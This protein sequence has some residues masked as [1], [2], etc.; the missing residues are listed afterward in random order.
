[1][2]PE[3]DLQQAVYGM[4]SSVKQQFLN[5][6]LMALFQRH[7]QHC[8]GYKNFIDGL[9]VTVTTA[10]DIPALTAAMF[11]YYDLK[12]VEDDL[13]FKVMHSSGTSSNQLSHIHL[14]RETAQ[15]QS[16]VLGKILQT[17][18][19]RQ[20]LPMLLV[21]HNTLLANKDL[22][23]ARGAGVQG[24]ALYGR[25][26]CY[27]LDE[28]MNVDLDAFEDFYQQHRAGPV[29]MFGFTYMVW[30]HL[31]EQLKQAN[32]HY[33][34]E[35][36][37]LL[38]SG[39]WKKLQA[40]SVSNDE[41]KQQAKK[42]LGQQ[43]SVHNFYGMVEQTGSIYLACE[44][45]RLHTPIYSDIRIR[46]PQTLTTLPHGSEGLVETLSI[47]PRSYPGHAVLTQDLGRIDGEDDC[48]CGRLG[49]Y[50]TVF[51]RQ[52]QAETRGCSDSYA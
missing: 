16:K 23:S 51:G 19:G 45:D 11:K 15:L 24:L 17:V 1:M 7:Y 31:F 44:Y 37:Y 3:L 43:T 18:I 38:H 27:L 22:F 35:K 14:D 6:H 29:V 39:G 28:A 46:D 50:F 52:K 41:F 12:S 25:D 32:K 13:V 49:K 8:A 33:E 20:R 21:D 26:H 10:E 5:T 36:L 48:P 40:L 42:L 2:L 34:F 47:L 9:G 4:P 30:L